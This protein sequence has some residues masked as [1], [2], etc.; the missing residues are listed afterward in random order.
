MEKHLLVKKSNIPGAGKGL[1][2]NK[3]I[4]KGTRIAEYKGKITTWKNVD[5]HDGL[6]AYIYYVNRN[7]VIDASKDKKNL[8]RYTNDVKGC[9]DGKK[10]SNNCIFIVDDSRVF[11]EAKKDIEA[12]SELFAGYGK[13]Y[14][15]IMRKNRSEAAAKKKKVTKL[16]AKKLNEAKELSDK[17]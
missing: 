17:V 4:A 2:T 11:L 12:K 14:W 1:F 6:N 13:E 15:D 9:E 7:L 16:P 8:A 10:L 5:H 3:F